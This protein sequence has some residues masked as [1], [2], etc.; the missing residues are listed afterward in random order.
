[1]TNFA[2]EQDIFDSLAAWGYVPE[3]WSTSDLALLDYG[4]ID[5]L[6]IAESV[7]SSSVN[8][9]A[10]DGYLKPI[11]S[12]EGWSPKV[13]RWD[14]ITDDA[15]QFYQTE[16]GTQVADDNIMVIKDNDHY[17]TKIFNVDDE[18]PWCANTD[19]TLQANISPNSWAEV[20]VHYTAKL[21]VEKNHYSLHPDFWNMVA[22]EPPDLPN[23]VFMWGVI[24]T[25]LDG[26]GTMHLEA[27]EFFI[28]LKRGC[29]WAFDEMEPVGLNELKQE[30]F[31][32][33]AF[34]NPA[35]DRMA[36][37]FNAPRPGEATAN[38]YNITGQL[39]ASFNKTA[40]TGKN[41]IEFRASDYA[42]GVYHIGLE[43]NGHTEYTK[44]VIR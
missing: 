12:M 41:F 39:V 7:G 4:A 28:I 17:I 32:L 6:V 44:V 21:A 33:L 31:K 30:S 26:D 11:V 22:I 16:S 18:I 3:Y 23:K 1:M 15:T 29:D 13:A 9:V 38:L 35:M 34:P 43:I 37:H 14:W 5:G 40:V 20:N 36:I 2:G 25:G 19:P 24:Q 8:S 27:P 10:S 42:A